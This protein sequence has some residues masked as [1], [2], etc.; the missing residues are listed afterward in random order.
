NHG[1][2]SRPRDEGGSPP[3]RQNR[4]VGPSQKEI[5][6]VRRAS[7]PSLSDAILRDPLQVFRQPARD[8]NENDLRDVVRMK[9]SKL[10]LKRRLPIFADFEEDERFVSR[11]DFFLPPVN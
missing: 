5:V 1:V 6:I 2:V 8:W 7:I 9:R 3:S 4:C 11:F 10:V